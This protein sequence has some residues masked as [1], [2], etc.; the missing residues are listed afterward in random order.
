MTSPEDLIDYLEMVL[1]RGGS[2]LHIAVGTP[3]AARIDG[4]VVPLAEDPLE[5]DDTRTLI[6]AILTESQR[7]RLENDLELDFALHV[8]G[9]GRFRGNAH[10]TKSSVEA[11]FRHIPDSIP[12]LADLGHGASVERLCERSRGL[13][14]VTGIT[15]SGKTTTLASM[16]QRILSRRECVAIT[17]EDP[18]EYILHHG[19][20]IV[21][22]RQIGLD[23]HSFPNA[24]RAALR[25]D[26]DVILVSELRDR[27]TI[28]TAIT[29]AETGHLV[30]GTLH[31]IDAPKTIDRL[32][33][34][35]P[36]EQQAQITTQLANCLLAIVTQRLIKREDAPGRVL[37]SELMLNNNAIAATIRERRVEQ[38]LGLIEIGRAEGMHTLDAS[39]AHLL[40][41]GYISYEDAIAHCRDEE[42]I[43]TAMQKHLRDQSART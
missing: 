12:D 21:K 27:E 5:P 39:L 6:F 2:D 42:F 32:V 41:G 40:V 14:L 33:D 9:L 36:A 17:I 15:G 26:P 20:G 16:V 1:A 37:A 11:A 3:P 4:L 31:T 13:V 22:Q 10:F 23:T 24:L 30:I 29:A 8:D 28:Q 43:Q 38:M 34:V 25:Q 35:F 19:R 18:I 7:S